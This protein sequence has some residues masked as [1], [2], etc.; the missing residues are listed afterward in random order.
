[1]LGY[2]YPTIGNAFMSADLKRTIHRVRMANDA[3]KARDSKVVV[4]RGEL[5]PRD[6]HHMSVSRPRTY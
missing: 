5:R 6:R 3:K 1:M 4:Y 2:Y